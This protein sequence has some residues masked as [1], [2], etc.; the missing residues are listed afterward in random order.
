[1]TVS[2]QALPTLRVGLL[3]LGGLG[4]RWANQVSL[5][6]AWEVRAALWDSCK[7]SIES[8]MP[9]PQFETRMLGADLLHGFACG[10]RSELGRS[11]FLAEQAH[12]NEWL[13][14]LDLLVVVMAAGGGFASGFAPELL[15]LAKSRDLP[16]WVLVQSPFSFEGTKRSENAKSCISRIRETAL[17]VPTWDSDQYSERFSE[18]GCADAAIVSMGVE[19]A[20]SVCDLLRMLFEEGMFDFSLEA[21]KSAC[22]AGPSRTMIGFG[23]ATGEGAFSAALQEVMDSIEDRFPASELRMDRLLV[24]LVGDSTM[25]AEAVQ[26]A[27]QAITTRLNHPSKCYYAATLDRGISGFR[28]TVYA[29]IAIGKQIELAELQKEGSLLPI[30]HLTSRRKDKRKGKA[31]KSRRPGTPAS[32]LDSQGLF[33][34]ILNE[35]NRGYFDDTPANFW[36]GIDLDTP[37]YLRRGLK[38]KV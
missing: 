23:K 6:P 28:I 37:A 8:L 9:D 5:D 35:S 12:C 24:T 20:E 30:L 10:G 26:E 29:S 14:G 33:D 7:N 19:A 21:L 36:N 38:L 25:Q 13:E 4:C 1:M 18:D 22:E 34:T 17:A 3:G 32:S 11:V 31:T 16:A 27:M 2:L 15:K